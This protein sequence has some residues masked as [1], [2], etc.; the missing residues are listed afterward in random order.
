MHLLAS[1]LTPSTVDD[2]RRAQ[3]G[4]PDDELFRR[5]KHHRG[6]YG[7]WEDTTPGDYTLFHI[8][9]AQF[10]H[11][12]LPIGQ[13]MHGYI[14]EDFHHTGAVE[15]F[16]EPEQL[17]AFANTQL[18]DQVGYF[19][20]LQLDPSHMPEIEEYTAGVLSFYTATR[21]ST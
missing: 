8:C 11:G 6:V 17:A 3:V 19:Y 2:P 18:A 16:F 1:C 20:V 9:P 10:F 15:A 13:G 7:K 4:L 21:E 12:Q 5:V 14:P